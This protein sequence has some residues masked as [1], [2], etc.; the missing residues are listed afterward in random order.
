MAHTVNACTPQHSS[1]QIA[2]NDNE[3]NQL[4]A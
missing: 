1:D 2:S 4:M 3:T